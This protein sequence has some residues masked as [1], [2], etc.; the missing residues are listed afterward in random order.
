[1]SKIIK[2]IKKFFSKFKRKMPNKFYILPEQTLYPYALLDAIVT[3][4][5]YDEAKDLFTDWK[6]KQ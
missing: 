5:F 6:G 1:M 2:S 3:R 4:R